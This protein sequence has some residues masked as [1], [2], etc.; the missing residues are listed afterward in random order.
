MVRD[1]DRLVTIAEVPKDKRAGRLLPS[2]TLFVRV[3]GW[4]GQLVPAF[5]MVLRSELLIGV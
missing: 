1:E 5:G 3:I 4:G 2:A